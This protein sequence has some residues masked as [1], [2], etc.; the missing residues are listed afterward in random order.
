MDTINATGG[1]VASQ[2]VPRDGGYCNAT[3]SMFQ[4]LLK[5]VSIRPEGRGVLQH[6][7]IV[8]DFIRLV[9]SIRPEGRGVLQRSQIV[10]IT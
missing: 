6:R 9:V 3:L 10:C 8:E 2:S 7:K 4:P 5:L 1:L